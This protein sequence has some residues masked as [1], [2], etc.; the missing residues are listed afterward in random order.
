MS[1]QIDGNSC[2]DCGGFQLGE[3]YGHS[4]SCPDFIS[5][6]LNKATSCLF[7]LREEHKVLGDKLT[8]AIDFLQRIA[9]GCTNDLDADGLG[10]MYRVN[11]DGCNS[12]EIAKTA[13]KKIT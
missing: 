13:L 2:T 9:K 5:D 10:H 7:K 3:P 1:I 4:C 8:V 11:C 12:E 6:Q